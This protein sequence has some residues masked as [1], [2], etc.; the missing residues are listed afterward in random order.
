M[1]RILA[2]LLFVLVVII[3]AK[4][5]DLIPPCEP[6]IT[7]VAVIDTGYNYKELGSRQINLC[8]TGHKDLSYRQEYDNSYHMYGIDPIPKDFHGHG[9]HIAGLIDSYGKKFGPGL[10]CI[11]IVKFY[12]PAYAGSMDTSTRAIEYANQ[13]GADYINYSAGGY[14]FMK[15]EETAVKKFLD[16]GGEMIAAA[17][18]E[19][20]NIDVTPYYPASLDRRIYVVGN[21]APT[22]YRAK[23]SNYGNTV[24]AWEM[25]TNVTMNGMTMTGT[26]QSAAIRTG[27]LLSKIKKTCK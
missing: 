9:T 23:S 11:V 8:K 22:G 5:A 24:N 15:D 4:T 7:K 17:G 19:S 20:K 18:N 26:S 2:I 12:D 10:F 13:I 25:G 16:R 14:Y 1:K 21:V 3:S 27:K 6:K